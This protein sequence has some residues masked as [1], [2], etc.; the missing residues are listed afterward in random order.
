MSGSTGGVGSVQE[1][2]SGARS[3]KPGWPLISKLEL[4]PLPTAPGCGRDHARHVLIEWGLTHLVDDAVLVVSELLTNAVQASRSLP[5][6]TPIVLRLLAN[7]AARQV[8]VEAWDQALESFDLTPKAANGVE[9]G[10]GLAVVAALSCRTG[11]G[12]MGDDFKCVWAEL[13]VSRQEAR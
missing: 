8:V 12:R 13:Q 4:G 9:H 3:V 10:R 2:S 6:P 7:P 11:V 5:T 1:P